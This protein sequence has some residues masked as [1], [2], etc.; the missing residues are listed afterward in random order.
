VVLE[1]E[2]IGH[3]FFKEKEAYPILKNVSFNLNKS[4]T[5]GIRGDNGAG[6]T[7]LFNIISG[8]Q[9]PTFGRIIKQNNLKV[10]TVFQNYNST[11]LPWLSVKENIS[12]PL[13]L[14]GAMQS[15]IDNRFKYL[16]DLL[17]F[18]NL[19]FTQKVEKLSG[20]QKQKIAIIRALM[21]EPDVLLLDEPF[22]NLDTNT[23]LNLQTILTQYQKENNTAMILVSHVLDHSIF[24]SDRIIL[25]GGSPSSIVSE[26]EINIE[27]TGTTDVLLSK[28]FEE[29]R[30]KIIEFEY[31][32]VKKSK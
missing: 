13:M 18:Q 20:G 6:K 27:K 22:S 23:T 26:F 29:V 14:S 32:Q 31:L 28:E 16:I 24:L 8:I 4:E 19:P 21:N 7:T 10:G 3:T 11:L 9:V 15:D 1:L 25:L 17:G 2:N 30:N 5:I 12:I